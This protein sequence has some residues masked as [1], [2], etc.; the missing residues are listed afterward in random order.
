MIFFKLL[1]V[2]MSP[3]RM[4]HMSTVV[5]RKKKG[6]NIFLNISI[7][8]TFSRTV[9][10]VIPSTTPARKAI[11]INKYGACVLTFANFASPKSVA[12]ARYATS[13]CI[14][15]Q[16]ITKNNGAYFIFL[17]EEKK[18]FLKEKKN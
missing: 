12:S 11:N 3:D 13:L 8:L 1:T 9:F 18:N 6:I 4:K 15:Q 2:L 16:I 7:N 5:K 14:N 17:L 10:A